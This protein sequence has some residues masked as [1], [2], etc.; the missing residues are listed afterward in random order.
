M[1]W[2]LPQSLSSAAT[3]DSTS[4]SLQ[5]SPPSALWASSNGKPMLRQPSWRGWKNRP[6]IKLLSGAAMSKNSIPPHFSEWIG[7]PQDSHAS[8]SPTQEPSEEPQMI[9]G[10]GN[11][12]QTSYT[13][14]TP[15][16]CFLRMCRDSL[17]EVGSDLSS[18]TLPTSGTMRS[19][20]CWEQTKLEPPTDASDSSYWPTP[21][22][23]DDKEGK[24]A[25]SARSQNLLQRTQAWPTPDAHC[26]KGG[27]TS[28][29]RADGKP[30]RGARDGQ[31]SDSTSLPAPL[32][33]TCGPDCSPKHR[34]LNPLFAEWLMGLPAGWTTVEIGSGPSATEW[35]LYKQQLRFAY[36]QIVRGGSY[37]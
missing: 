8:P 13:I 30:R 9:D 3:E 36:L 17:L 28:K 21:K 32:T 37:E 20:R 34:K 29:P 19:G 33:S 18:L 6:W 4:P 16:G 5:S 35:S 14:F 7:S 27:T 11:T 22:A 26:W 12:L 24:V 31:L 2:L 15:S 1:T 10:S 25:K 23:S